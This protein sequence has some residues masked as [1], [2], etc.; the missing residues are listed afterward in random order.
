MRGFRY[1][2][3]LLLAAALA[4]ATIVSAQRKAAKR[5]QPVKPTG[6]EAEAQA[7]AKKFVNKVVTRC[8]DDSYAYVGAFLV[9][10]KGFHLK[11]RSEPVSTA[12]RLNGIEARAVA[13]VTFDAE[14]LPTVSDEWGDAS[15]GICIAVTKRNGVWTGK[16]CE[17]LGGPLPEKKPTCEEIKNK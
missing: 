4:G 6:I 11:V 9:R 3:V 10:W 1:L 17:F 5:Q 8:G 16:S 12:D 2:C 7:E 15:S 14:Q 13:T